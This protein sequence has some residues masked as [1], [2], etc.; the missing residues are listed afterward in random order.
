MSFVKQLAGETAIYGISYILSRI[1]H[2]VVFTVYLTNRVFATEPA[3]YG[4]YT[5]MYAYA[6]ML[7]ILFTYRME[8]AYFRFGNQEDKEGSAFSTASTSILVSTIFLVLLLLL[9]KVPIAEVLQYPNQSQYVTYFALIIGLDALAAI[10]FAQLRLKN[11]PYRFAFI[12]ILNV[13]ITLLLVMFFLELC[14]WL[15]GK[16]YT[17][18]STIY[19]PERRL[20]LVFISNLIASAC[21]LFL[22]LP[23]MKSTRFRFSMVLWKKMIHYVIPLIIVG[24]AGVFNQSFAVP[25]LKYLL[26]G[27]SI[28]NLG[29]AGLYSA[30][31]KLAIL[32]NLFTQSFNYAAEPFFFKQAARADAKKTYADVA[33]A[34]TLSASIVF[35]FIL[36]YMDLVQMLIGTHYREGIF[37][38]VPIL[39]LAYFFLGIYYNFSIWYKITDKT[40]YG[41]FISLGGAAITLVVA[42]AFIGSLGKIA[43]A[44]A[45]LACYFFMA[46]AGYITGKSHY[47]I[48]YRLGKMAAYILFAVIIYYLSIWCR[49]STTSAVVRLAFNTALMLIYIVIIYYWDRKSIR[50]WIGMD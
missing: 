21:V 38:I 12:K 5:D 18:L 48:P 40:S 1:L 33:Q 17:S 25:L 44:W 11:K 45:A 43:M 23:E 49:H 22:L 41:A 3:L 42:F 6:A 24:A 8:T 30:A 15:I 9:S 16:G 36:L 13:V 46:V 28:E 7:L 50:S 34:F 39:L 19:S 20:D 37:V 26:P 14:P 35:L 10:P 2:Y 4:I 47:P 31:A 29:E 32:M 27:T